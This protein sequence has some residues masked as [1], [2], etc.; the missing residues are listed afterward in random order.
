M[1]NLG[2]FFDK[3]FSQEEGYV[4]IARRSAAS[5]QFSQHFFEWPNDRNLIVNMCVAS[6]PSHDVFYSPALF[7]SDK[8]GTKENVKGASTAWCDFDG[9]V[10][11]D[12]HGVP[13]PTIKVIS[14]DSDHQHWYWTLDSFHKPSEIEAL[15]RKLVATLNADTVWDAGRLLRPPGTY[16]FKRNQ[17]ASLLRLGADNYALTNFSHLAAPSFQDLEDSAAPER[18]PNLDKVIALS[19]IKP[20]LW[21]LIQDG[22]PKGYRSEGLFQVAAK[23]AEE[24]MKAENILTILLYCDNRWGKFKGRTDQKQRLWQI[25]QKAKMKY[26]DEPSVETEKSILTMSLSEVLTS[27]VEMS[28]VWDELLEEEGL[29]LLTGQSGVGKTQFSLQMAFKFI[30]SRAFLNQ[31][32]QTP[33][34]IG[35]LSLEMGLRHLKQFLQQMMLGYSEEEQR[36]INE[37]LVIFPLGEPL[38]LDNDKGKTEL[39]ALIDRHNLRGV[40]ID[41]L[42]NTV[43]GSLKDDDDMR[44]LFNWFALLREN[45]HVFLCIIHHHRKGD[46]K[47]KPNGLSDV[48]GSQYITSLSTSVLCMWPASVG[49]AIELIRL[50]V[51]MAEMGPSIFIKRTENLDFGLASTVAEQQKA[52]ESLNQQMKQARKDKA[53]DKAMGEKTSQ[54][55][56]ALGEI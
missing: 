26:P 6:S 32:S 45:M 54:W 39:K 33:G 10:P 55:I 28:W 19:T 29:F 21:K 20:S 52:Q 38:F 48:Y 9:N 41:S 51:R 34:R 37:N 43:A 27:E 35:F 44:I 2:D 15:N 17:R 18:L 31:E 5:G 3:V 24:H 47:N 49:K 46:A 4:R 7:L 42:G 1:A 8:D 23:C 12:L 56:G 14:S 36:I 22:R 13:E 11:V 53:Q 16:N 40:F 50:K 25:V 30:L